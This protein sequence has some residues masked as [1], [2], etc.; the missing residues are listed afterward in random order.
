MLCVFRRPGVEAGGRG[1]LREGIRDR[2]TERRFPF[3]RGGVV[4]LSAGDQP[5]RCD[6]QRWISLPSTTTT[7]ALGLP[8]LPTNVIFGVLPRGTASGAPHS[9]HEQPTCSTI[10]MRAPPLRPAGFDRLRCA[11]RRAG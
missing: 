2:A 4:P 7:R 5:G 8:L 6:S 3:P 1:Y 10:A 9:E 11:R